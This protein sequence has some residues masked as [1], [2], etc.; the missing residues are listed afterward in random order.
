VAIQVAP[1]EPF[2]GWPHFRRELK[3]TFEIRKKSLKAC[4]LTKG[5]MGFNCDLGLGKRFEAA[6]YREMA[7]AAGLSRTGSGTVCVGL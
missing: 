6:S 4:P 5:L 1:G 2:Q 7:K 3:N